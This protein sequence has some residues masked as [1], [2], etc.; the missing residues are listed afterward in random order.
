MNS[1]FAS[2]EQKRKA[3]LEGLGRIFLYKV[4]YHYH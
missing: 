4:A 2:L 3:I 1:L